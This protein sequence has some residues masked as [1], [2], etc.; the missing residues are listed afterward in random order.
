MD[1]HNKIF[2]GTEL[3]KM[4]SAKKIEI[5]K[6]KTKTEIN[7]KNNQNISIKLLDDDNTISITI[8]NLETTY[9]RNP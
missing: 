3:E 7:L 8:N 2:G 5:I 4:S 9:N 1:L 6:N